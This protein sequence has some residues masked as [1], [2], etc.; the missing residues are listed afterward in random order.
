MELLFVSNIDNQTLYAVDPDDGTVAFAYPFS[1]A[2]GLAADEV[3]GVR[4]LA[5]EP[6]MGSVP[7]GSFLDIAVTFDAADLFGGDYFANIL[8][9]S[10]DPANPEM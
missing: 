5:A 8:V 1:Y 3:A 4:W 6:E 7:A 2:S 10:N 9:V